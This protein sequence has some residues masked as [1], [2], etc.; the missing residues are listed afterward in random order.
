MPEI[1]NTIS[2]RV[3]A[4]L[5]SQ[6]IKY[7]V[8]RYC[9]GRSRPKVRS[10]AWQDSKYNPVK[11][12]GNSKSSRKKKKIGLWAGGNGPSG[13]VIVLWHFTCCK[14]RRPCFWILDDL[15]YFTFSEIFS[16]GDVFIALYEKWNPETPRAC[17]KTH[18]RVK[19]KES[20]ILNFPRKTN[21]GNIQKNRKK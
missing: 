5:L 8:G 20:A 12:V 15:I 16:S 13:W 10:Q 18:R 6:N 21:N 11:I 7:F 4:Y 14:H 2:F 3:L 1:L 19:R 9:L 17:S